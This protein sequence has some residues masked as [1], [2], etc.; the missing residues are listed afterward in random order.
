MICILE[1]SITSIGI[2]AAVSKQ[3]RLP[4]ETL[5]HDKQVQTWWAQTNKKTGKLKG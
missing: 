3:L 5:R 2:G 4:N 1:K